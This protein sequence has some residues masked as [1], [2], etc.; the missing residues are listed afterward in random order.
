MFAFEKKHTHSGNKV[1][2]PFKAVPVA[3]DVEYLND[4]RM[5][6]CDSLA[7]HGIKA[8]GVVSPRPSPATVASTRS[9]AAAMRGRGGGFGEGEGGVSEED[10]LGSAFDY[11]QRSSSSSSDSRHQQIPVMPEGRY[12][13]YLRTLY[14][15]QTAEH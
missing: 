5:Y 3:Q 6:D 1:P 7:W 4:I 15:Y 2:E 13:E 10:A 12:G 9:A 8:L 11:F 14:N